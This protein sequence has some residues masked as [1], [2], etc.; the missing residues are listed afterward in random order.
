MRA[1]LIQLDVSESES[2]GDR[3]SRTMGLVDQASVGSDLVV[4]PELWNV[5]AF[6]VEGARAHAESLDGPLVER[7]A[8]AAAQNSV[9]LH[10]G[11][12]AEITPD[13]RYFN[14]SVLF[15]PDGRL[16]ATYRKIHLF[17]FT[18]GETTL[19]S[20]GEEVV[21]TETPIGPTG[22]ATCYDLRFPELYRRFVDAGALA[23]I[24]GSGWPTPRISHWSTLVRAR[25]IENQM[26]VIAC[27]EVGAHAG[28]VL[29]GRSIIVDATGEVMAEAG[30]GEEIL[31]AEIDRERV[32]QW[33]ERFPVL[34][35]RRL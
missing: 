22:L 16:V 29:G 17:G 35:D 24:M 34:A 23:V 9:W 3:V 6:N 19:M 8:Q 28:T 2:I 32:E 13:G 31:R 7:L 25:A 12:F 11:S 10:G 15:A 18:G 33:R 30:D 1:A 27:N 20:A 14:T 5:G 21:V 26:V 4:L